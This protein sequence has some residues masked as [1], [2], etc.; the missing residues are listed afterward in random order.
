MIKITNR[1]IA[2]SI[3]HTIKVNLMFIKSTTTNKSIKL[4]VIGFD[5]NIDS[6]IE[7]INTT[8]E[9]SWKK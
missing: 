7:L 1:S 9:S 8:D 3:C 2:L 4:L 5:S 6:I